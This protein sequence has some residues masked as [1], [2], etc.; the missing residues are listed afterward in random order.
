MKDKKNKVIIKLPDYYKEGLLKA[1]DF[2]GDL[3]T[4]ADFE[5]YVNLYHRNA[6]LRDNVFS[7]ED[8]KIAA[9]RKTITSYFLMLLENNMAYS[10]LVDN[11]LKKGN[12]YDTG[13]EE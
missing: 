13:N 9:N 6:E 4:G 7:M 5:T 11:L 12:N 1:L 10:M 2:N 8:D 3:I